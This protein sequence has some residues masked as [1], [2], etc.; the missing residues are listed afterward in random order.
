V[1]WKG[2]LT[3]P[4][5]S[6]MLFRSRP[7]F[8]FQLHL[9]LALL[10][11]LVLYPLFIWTQPWLLGTYVLGLL[12]YLG[13]VYVYLTWR[14]HDVQIKQHYLGF[15]QRWGPWSRRRVFRYKRIEKV[16]LKRYRSF[17]LFFPKYVEVHYIEPDG[18]FRRPRFY[19]YGLNLTA[20]RQQPNG[21]EQLYQALAQR[22]VLVLWAD[23]V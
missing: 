17:Q 7:K 5:Y 11:L 21:F 9:L 18:R 20:T 12:L 23:E 2:S 15:Y 22:G 1:G 8:I 19:C 10:P 6:A 14:S 3:I 16:V 13:L 4:H